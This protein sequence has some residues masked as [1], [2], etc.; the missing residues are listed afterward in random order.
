VT[1]NFR[2][3]T[4]LPT[5]RDRR[6]ARQR[7]AAGT[8]WWPEEGVPIV[9]DDDD[10]Y[11]GSARKGTRRGRIKAQRR[12]G[13]KGPSIRVQ[14]WV[15]THDPDEKSSMELAVEALKGEPEW[16]FL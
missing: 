9:P 7:K 13:I 10:D 14:T 15:Q 16:T 1:R 5:K 12:K 4:T 6:K 2:A 11:D 3:S 8:I